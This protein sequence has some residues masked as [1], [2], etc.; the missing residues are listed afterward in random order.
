M[1]MKSNIHRKLYR[2]D[3]FKW[4]MY[5]QHAALNQK[6]FDKRKA[7]RKVRRINK[8]EVDN[9]SNG[10]Q[11]N[12]WLLPWLSRMYVSDCWEGRR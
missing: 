9:G 10:D 1:N 5:C 3:Y 4:F 11:R 7:K 8:M 6:R 12:D 2:P